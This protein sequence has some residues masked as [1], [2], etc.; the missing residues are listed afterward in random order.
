MNKKV[1]QKNTTI[2][3][4]KMYHK[5]TTNITGNLCYFCS[6]FVPIKPYKNTKKIQQE[7]TT[8]R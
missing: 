5:N 8:I 3:Y 7:I 1:L 4:S 6:D 2:I